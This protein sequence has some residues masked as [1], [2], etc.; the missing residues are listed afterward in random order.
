M[1]AVP[2]SQGIAHDEQTCLARLAEDERAI[3]AR[4]DSFLAQ[5]GH[6]PEEINALINELNG[7]LNHLHL[8]EPCVS[9]LTRMGRPLAAQRL[10][11]MIADLRGAIQHHQDMHQSTIRRLQ[12]IAAIQREAEEA[13]LGIMRA[14]IDKGGAAADE[15]FKKWSG[16]FTNSCVNC[17]Y[18]LGDLYYKLKI[19]P[20]CGLFLRR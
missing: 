13:C 11:G 1:S 16:T 2:D 14:V 15:G 20:N 12:T 4:I 18:Y 6:S 3:V 5:P 19:C 7:R 9:Q 8:Y 10:G 17:D